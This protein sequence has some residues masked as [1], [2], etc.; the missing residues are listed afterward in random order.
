MTFLIFIG[1]FSSIIALQTFY[2]NRKKFFQ[3]KKIFIKLNHSEKRPSTFNFKYSL[4]RRFLNLISQFGW[5][6]GF[7]IYER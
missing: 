7:P 1:V 5:C 4:S 3:N 2:I 6:D